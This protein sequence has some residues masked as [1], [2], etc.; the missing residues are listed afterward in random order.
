[1]PPACF[2]LS[3]SSI[4]FP[5]TK[6]IQNPRHPKIKPGSR[7]AVPRGKKGQDRIYGKLGVKQ[8]TDGISHPLNHPHQEKRHRSK[9]AAEHQYSHNPKIIKGII[10]QS[11]RGQLLFRHINREIHKGGNQKFQPCKSP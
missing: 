10:K 9:D 11:D 7:I 1:M 6:A 8:I 5:G 3:M 4:V 2:H